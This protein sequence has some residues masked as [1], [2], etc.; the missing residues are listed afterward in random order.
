MKAATSSIPDA[1]S[2][3]HLAFRRTRPPRASPKLG[4]LYIYSILSI[5]LSRSTRLALDTEKRRFFFI[6]S[7]VELEV[8][9]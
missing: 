6:S 4:T 7:V 3:A 8:E 5:P 2:V 9:T 1:L